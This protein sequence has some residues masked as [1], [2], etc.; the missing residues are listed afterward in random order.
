MKDGKPVPVML[1]LY[2]SFRIYSNRT[3]ANA[4]PEVAAEDQKAGTQ[5]P[6]P[7]S[8]KPLNQ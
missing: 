2:V 1:D 7:Y 4:N 5:L 8:L 3:A 6:G